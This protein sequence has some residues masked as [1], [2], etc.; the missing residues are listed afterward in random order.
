MLE[1]EKWH[2]QL[3]ALIKSIIE[4][5]NAGQ[6]EEKVNAMLGELAGLSKKVIG[7]LNVAEERAIQMTNQNRAITKIG[8]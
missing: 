6:D 8:K 3:H 7:A 1:V 4:A 2:I 5:H